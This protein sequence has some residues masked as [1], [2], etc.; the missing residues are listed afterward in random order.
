MLV[1]HLHRQ[2]PQWKAATK[3]AKTLF[4]YLAT[5]ANE[6]TGRCFVSRNTIIEDAILSK[7]QIAAANGELLD[8]GLVTKIVSGNS[9]QH[10]ANTYCLVTRNMLEASPKK[11]TRASPKKGTPKDTDNI[12]HIVNNT[13]KDNNNEDMTSSS[14]IPLPSSS[15]KVRYSNKEM[16][17]KLTPIH[18]AGKFDS[19]L[20]LNSGDYY[21]PTHFTK[22]RAKLDSLATFEEQ[23]EYLKQLSNFRIPKNTTKLNNGKYEMKLVDHLNDAKKI[24]QAMYSYDESE[25]KY[26]LVQSVPISEYP[27]DLLE[28]A[29]KERYVIIKNYDSP[30]QED[31]VLLNWTP[32]KKEKVNDDF[33]WF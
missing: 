9:K 1:N 27:P 31:E 8:S 4:L 15:K 13:E 19:L 33:L 11:G 3:K 12:S 14:E 28:Q 18:L 25:K 6:E 21:I 5:F 20:Q 17:E 16:W 2:S 30:Y 26:F 32:R 22:A 24:I 7:N 29:I 10:L 23:E